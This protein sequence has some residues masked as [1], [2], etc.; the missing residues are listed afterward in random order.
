MCGFHGKAGEVCVLILEEIDK[1]LNAFFRRRLT[2][3]GRKMVRGRP[4]TP[5]G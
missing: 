4:V 1:R 5:D 2:Q 3:E